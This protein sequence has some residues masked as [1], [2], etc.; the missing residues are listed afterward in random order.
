MKSPVAFASSLV[1][2]ALMS[3]PALA[4]EA[5]APSKPDLA[6]GQA[7]AATCGACHTS[8]GTRGLPTYPILQGQHAEYLVKQLTEFKASKRANPIM[9][10]MAAP[11]TE[12]D[13]K[14]VA[15]F[16][17]SKKPVLGAA[18]NK[19]TVALGEKIYRGGIAEKKVPA[20]AG[21]HGPS[22]AGLPVQYPRLSGQHAEYVELQLTTFRSGARANSQQMLDIAA[23]MSDA[24]IKAV[25]DYVA[26]LR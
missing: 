7:I 11:L 25:A 23:R 3:V 8:D 24:E 14:N 13:M 4:A 5:A 21:C 10:G 1:L 6:R 16:Y 12:A 17:A 9:N 19:D 20:C 18:K 22:G 2:A 15:A 26:G